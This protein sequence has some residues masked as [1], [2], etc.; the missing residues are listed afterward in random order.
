MG[1]TTEKKK[2]VISNFKPH[3][4]DT[5]SPEVQI[6][7]LS[8]RISHLTEHFKKHSKDHASRRGLLMMV[9]QRRRLLDYL[10]RKDKL[11]TQVGTQRH[12]IPNFARVKELV[13]DG[14]IGELQEVCAWGN[15]QLPKP[16]YL[17]AAGEPPKTFHWDLWLGPA[18]EARYNRNRGLYQFRW[19]FDYSGGQITN[20]GIHFLDLIHWALG[21]DA[22]SAVTATNVLLSGSASAPTMRPS[23]SGFMSV[24]PRPDGSSSHGR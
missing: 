13:R 20:N 9:A 15:R 2:G 19:F 11:A 8:G 3:E 24:T 18:P 23:A 17:P 16:G 1:L 22:P 6:A 7:L 4:A 12:E 10:K 21:Q 14:A 5:G